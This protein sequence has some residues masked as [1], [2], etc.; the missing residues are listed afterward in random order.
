LLFN[1]ATRANEIGLKEATAAAI[2]LGLRVRILKASTTEEIDSAFASFAADRPDC[3]LILNDPLF[4]TRNTQIVLLT[5]RNGIPAMLSQREY[6]DVGGLMSYGTSTADS[7]RWLGIYTARVL[8]GAKPSE[9]PVV[10]SSKF[11]F[12]INLQTARTLGLSIP[13]T[14]LARADEVIE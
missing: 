12:V 3:L 10:Q 5:A 7:Y 14:L 6:V 11:E 4:T 8:K 1:P 2:A 9:L 13:P